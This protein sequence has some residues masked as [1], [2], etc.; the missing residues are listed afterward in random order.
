MAS[1]DAIVKSEVFGSRTKTGILLAI[2]LFEETFY[3]EL[4]R[5]L[6]LAIYSVQRAVETLEDE[7]VLRTTALGSERRVALNPSYFAAKEL[8][9]LLAKVADASPNLTEAVAAQRRRP[10]KRGKAI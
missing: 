4:S 7:G 5:T 2:Y 1:I 10:R 9:A 6:C 3:R 8:R